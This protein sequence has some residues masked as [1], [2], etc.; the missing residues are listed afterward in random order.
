MQKDTGA[1]HYGQA[2]LNCA[3]A[4]SKCV[5]TGV[6]TRGCDRCRR[7]QK[8][9][10]PAPR[11]RKRKAP[12]RTELLEQKVEDLMALLKT[13]APSQAL[14]TPAP[15]PFQT[16]PSLLPIDR[17]NEDV[18][19]D[20]STVVP[21]PLPS[22]SVPDMTPDEEEEALNAFRTEKLPWMPIMHIPETTRPEDLKKEYPFV[23]LCI[24]AIQN[25]CTPHT[26]IL[27]DRVREEAGRRM[28]LECEKSF[29]LLQGSLIYLG[30]VTFAC[31][32][33][34]TSLCTY[35]QMALAMLF[36]L[37]L[38]KPPPP[39]PNLAVPT[40]N[41]A[42]HFTKR[43]IYVSLVRTMNERRALLG[44]YFL[45]S[46]I[47]QFVGLTEPMTWTLHMTECLEVLSAST[48]TPND[49]IL[50]QLVSIRRITD[51]IPMGTW[52]FNDPTPLMRAPYAWHLKALESQ[53]TD[54]TS[55]M[56]LHLHHN[57][58]AT[59]YLLHLKVALY[60][61]AL[62]NAPAEPCN[63]IDIDRLDHL[64]SCLNAIKGFCDIILSVPLTMFPDIPM[65]VYI[66]M[67][68]C[69]IALFRLSMFDYPG[70]DKEAVRRDVDLLGITAQLAE[71]MAQV[72]PTLGIKNNGMQLDTCTRF[73][74]K[75]LGL[76]AGWEA[77]MSNAPET[78][79]VE[80][81]DPLLAM[82]AKFLDPWSDTSWLSGALMSGAFL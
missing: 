6:G 69:F 42:G 68:H 22:S 3:R 13:P 26:R 31:P 63:D 4:K 39:D 57:K 50:V 59:L 80:T 32:S 33:D 38:Q 64:Y 37:R 36:N 5:M 8:D 24:R 82:D 58:T 55:R 19:S 67:S 30:W 14:P 1:A 35:L 9:C 10:R 28:M 77:R 62:L 47:S 52:N 53:L 29:D 44:C 41:V 45:S 79:E 78:N 11:L 76:R 21:E 60:E 49:A 66:L 23:W 56:P 2:C 71:R 48:E 72:A 74:D 51:K 54:L 70:W 43:K 65:S 27:C 46:A 81:L 18:A 12:S 34:K 15:D 73:A 75:I 40:C 7:M 25:K 20:A 16:C 17:A 61:T